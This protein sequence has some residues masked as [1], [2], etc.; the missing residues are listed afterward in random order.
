MSVLLRQVRGFFGDFLMLRLIDSSGDCPCS[1]SNSGA[2]LG[3]SVIVIQLVNDIYVIVTDVRVN[4]VLFNDFVNFA[5]SILQVSD[6][7]SQ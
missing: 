3:I 1:S 6:S 2:L 4:S 7:L 5:C